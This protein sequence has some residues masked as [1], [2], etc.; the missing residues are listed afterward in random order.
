M[1]S[2]HIQMVLDMK[3]IGRMTNEK[4]RESFIG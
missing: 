2:L 1:E 3:E 4:V